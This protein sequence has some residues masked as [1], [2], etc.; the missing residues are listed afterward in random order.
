MQAFASDTGGKAFYN[1]SFLG[2]AV[3]NAL[4]DGANY[5]TLW[6]IRQANTRRAESGGASKWR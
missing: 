6:R 2:V 4:N 5:C 3:D 1:D